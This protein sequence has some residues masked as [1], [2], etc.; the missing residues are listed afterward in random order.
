ML[1]Q[2]KIAGA[3]PISKEPG[4]EIGPGENIYEN[5]S[6]IQRSIAEGDLDFVSCFQSK[7]YPSITR[8]GH[9][10]LLYFSEFS[11]IEFSPPN[12]V[13]HY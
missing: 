7:L 2:C 12:N 11:E 9:V 5:A 1:F 6:K 8:L 10:W 3:H 13:E 4:P